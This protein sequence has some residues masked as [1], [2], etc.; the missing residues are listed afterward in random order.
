MRARRGIV[1]LALLLCGA[2]GLSVFP[3]ACSDVECE[4]GTLRMEATLP[5]ELAE[6]VVVVELA[7]E[8]G[9]RVVHQQALPV[10]PGARLAQADVTIPGGYPAGQPVVITAVAKRADGAPVG[11][12]FAA[13]VLPSGCAAFA[14]PLVPGTLADGGSLDGGGFF[15]DAGAVDVSRDATVSV[16]GAP[17]DA[18]SDDALPLD[19]SLG[20]ASPADASPADA[21]VDAQPSLDAPALP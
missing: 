14:F 1:G 20:D 7:F 5:P 8:L 4:P 11:T 3:L 10:A 6:D 9:G 2:L 16:D 18:A 13:E 17:A 19:A 12:W 21:E 15:Q